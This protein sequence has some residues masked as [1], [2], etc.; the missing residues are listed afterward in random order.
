MGGRTLIGPSGPA[1]YGSLVSSQRE[2]MT[3]PYERVRAALGDRV[4]VDRGTTC[5]CLCPAHD[6]N[7]AS[8]SIT[9]T[10]EGVVLMKCH[11][12]CELEAILRALG[13]TKRDLFP[14][15]LRTKGPGKS[16]GA[17]RTPTASHSSKSNRGAPFGKI[18]KTYDYADEESSVLFQSVRLEPKSF[19]QRRPNGKGGWIWNLDGVR[20]VPYRLPQLLALPLDS[21]IFIAEGE[22]DVD[23][24]VSLGLEATTNPA[25]A[26]KFRLLDPATVE[27]VFRDRAVVILLDNDEPGRRH[28]QQII[29]T[30]KGIVKELRVVAFPELAAK[31]DVSDWLDGG[32]TKEQLLQRVQ[33]SV[34]ADLLAVPD[35][36]SGTRDG[37][38]QRARERTA[39]SPL[40]LSDAALERE[41]VSAV[42][43]VQEHGAPELLF[44]SSILDRLAELPSIEVEGALAYLRSRLKRNFSATTMR[45]LLRERGYQ[46]PARDQGVEPGEPGSQYRETPTGIVWDRPTR[47]G[48]EVVPLTNFLARVIAEVHRDDGM[49]VTKDFEVEAKLGNQT[50]TFTVPVKEFPLMAWP[51]ANLGVRGI[52]YPGASIKDHAR[53][54]IQFL[55]GEPPV[56]TIFGH[57]G[58]RNLGEI[59]WVYLYPGGF[60]SSRPPEWPLWP[61]WPLSRVEVDLACGEKKYALPPPPLAAETVVAICAVLRLLQLGPARLTFPLVAGAFRIAINTVE[62]A[63]FLY[64]ITGV[65]KSQLAA[66]LQAFW[67]KEFDAN[68]LPGSWSSTANSLEKLAYLF[69]YAVFVIDDFCPVGGA[70]DQ[71]RMYRELDRVLRALGNQAG[72]GRM[73]AD[74]SSR[75]TYV[76]RSL[77]V[78]TAEEL[79]SRESGLARTLTLQVSPGDIDA[80]RLTACQRDAATGLYAQALSAFLRWAGGRLEDLRAQIAAR[81]DV[82][83]DSYHQ[84]AR[85]RRTGTTTADLMAGFE[86]F[87]QFATETGAVTPAEGRQLLDRCGDALLEAAAGHAEHLQAA[88]PAAEFIDRVRSALSS[89]KAYL[90]DRDGGVPDRSIAAAY[91]WRRSNPGETA[92]PTPDWKPLGI[93]IGWV[94]GCSTYLDPHAAIKAANEMSTETGRILFSVQTLGGHLKA[95]DMLQSWDEGRGKVLVRRVLEGAQKKILHLRPGLLIA[96]ASGAIGASDGPNEDD[97]PEGFEAEEEEPEEAEQGLGGGVPPEVEAEHGSSQEE[98]GSEFPPSLD[99]LADEIRDIFRHDDDAGADA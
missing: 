4:R 15:R 51:A 42:A 80:G 40:G 76:P 66:L 78:V 87:V 99:A 92:S 38:Q 59:G 30:L 91:G 48:V 9:E 97:D 68:H 1:T 77:I 81:R 2:A 19:R 70:I 88:E 22:K 44:D 73:K 62:F 21:V 14:E 37:G 49:A 33:D 5:S 45:R 86:V 13:L 60:L 82:L 26:E 67:G 3:S 54:A 41:L 31:G 6:D 74:T 64:G 43:R 65:F 56:R 25:G 90:S 18:V 24:L 27:R 85:H 29:R 75:T 20:R 84:S 35:P 47:E 93:H 63:L 83:R 17:A 28:G 46:S 16:L 89:G 36:G 55:S 53:A 79:P 7:N 10:G 12:N 94:D 71:Q 57:L 11:A 32:G 98:Q 95:R 69:G 8:L 50:F 34:L 96:G 61:Q 39:E 52:L 72:R 23:R 58:W